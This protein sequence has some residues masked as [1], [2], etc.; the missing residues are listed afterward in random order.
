M[1][2]IGAGCHEIRIQDRDVTWRLFHYID[3][4]AIVLLEIVD[5]KTRETPERVLDKC[6]ARLAQYKA[7]R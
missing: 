1:P 7:V 4:D 6:K 5:K 2:S 3:T